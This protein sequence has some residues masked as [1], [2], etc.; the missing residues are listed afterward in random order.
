MCDPELEYISAGMHD[1]IVSE[2]GN[3]NSLLVKSKSATS[4]YLDSK[5]PDQQIGKELG[6]NVIV[7]HSLVCTDQGMRLLV[8]LIELVPEEKEI[9]S[10]TYDVDMSN[11]LN[12]YRDITKQIARNI[13]AGMSDQEKK[14]F[15]AARPVNSV[16]YKKYLQGIF[17]MNKLTHEGAEQGIQFLKDA[18]SIDPQEPLPYLGL[19]LGYSNAGHVSDAGPEAPRLAREYALK[20]LEL[21]STLAEAY[22]VLATQYLYNDWNFPATEK[23]LQKSIALNPNIAS[24]HYTNGWYLLLKGKQ[25]EAEKE[26]RLS[27]DL[28]PLDPF[29]VGYL[30]WFYLWVGK[31]D[32]AIS[33][34]NRALELN[35]HDP[36]ALYVL[37]S[38]YAVK[39]MYDQAIET[40]KKG[41]GIEPMYRCGLGVAYAKAG[42]RKEALE[43]AEKLEKEN[44]SWNS[45]GLIEIYAALGDKDK[46]IQWLQASYDQHDQFF[47]WNTNNP[48]YDFISDD[49]RFLEIKGRIQLPG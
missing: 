13:K 7:K 32:D 40:H 11:S 38:A 49:P 45:W 14:Y 9:W 36:M 12:I 29:C 44:N 2:L 16:L 42:R 27:V 3:V 30:A 8:Q 43:I 21:D 17:Y 37:G 39:G 5:L 35:P 41:I 31:T 19:A 10:D 22:T 48:H 28:E 24:L 26:M 18:M 34:S 25:E 23:A 46:A 15:N 33:M 20:A 6:A 47:P 1:A 4:K